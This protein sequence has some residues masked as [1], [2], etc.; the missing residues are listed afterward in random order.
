MKKRQSLE[1]KEKERKRHLEKRRK[2]R[3][4]GKQHAYHLKWKF[5]LTVEQYDEMLAAQNGACYICRGH[6]KDLRRLSVDHDHITGKVRGL[7]CYPCN[8][9]L[10]Y[11]HDQ[12]SNLR[13]A[14]DYLEE[15]ESQRTD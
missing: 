10:G 15:H 7:L 4:A 13:R 1:W 2:F 11:F 12:V 14:A 8:A 6:N 5:N 9:G 3:E